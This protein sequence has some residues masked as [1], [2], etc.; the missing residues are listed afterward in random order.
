MSIRLDAQN[1]TRFEVLNCCEIWDA[2]S[3]EYMHSNCQ[4]IGIGSTE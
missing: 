4:Q 1:I 3:L 2:L